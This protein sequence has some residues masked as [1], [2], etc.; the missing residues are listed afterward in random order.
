MFCISH[1]CLRRWM[2]TAYGI[3]ILAAACVSAQAQPDLTI[4]KSHVGNF[5][6]GTT[7][8]H[9]IVVTNIGVASTSGT[10]TVTDVTPAGTTFSSASGTG[11]TCTNGAGTTVC[12]STQFVAPGGS[13]PPISLVF[14]IPISALSGYTNTA[15]VSG[16]GESNTANN[17]AFDTTVVL[18]PADLTISK[19]HAGNFTAGNQGVY[20][21][22]VTNVGTASTSGTVTVTDLLP[23]GM[24]LA[25][26]TGSGWTCIGST[27]ISCTST[28]TVVGGSSFPVINLTVNVPADAPASLTNTATVAGGGEFNTANN[29]VNDPTTIIPVTDLT[30]SK[31]HKGNLIQGQIGAAYS[32]IVTN[33]G[34]SNTSGTTTVV[35]VLPAGLSATAISGSGWTCVLATLTCTSTAAIAPGSSFPVITVTVN[36]ATNSP[37]SVTN[38]AN[39]ASPNDPNNSNNAANDPTTFLPLDFLVRY[40]ANL[41]SGDAVINI[42]N[43]GANGAALA[44]PGFGGAAGNICMNVYAFSPDEQLVSCCSCLITPNGLVSLSVNQDL[45]NN[46]LTGVRP[47][48]VVVKLVNTLAGDGTGASCTNSAALAG[49]VAFPT[50]GGSMAFGTTVHVGAAGSF[51]V[52][53]TPFLKAT[54]S[55]AE[56]ASITNRCTNII[57]NGSTFGICRSCRGGGLAAGR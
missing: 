40:A 11:W 45:V 37:L 6:Q 4:S 39:V 47:N 43:T 15:N 28:Q 12:T 14:N 9:T 24:T 7:G 33:Q 1:S 5:V 23:G 52:A 44:G 55:P 16:G 31:S 10:V 22:T 48:S 8:T 26:F 53:E 50:A 42:T 25:S 20:G 56:L 46:T 13:L 30:I 41:T 54:L 19:S 38:S 3:M 2:S 17:S 21:I 27:T 34:P 32:I 35:D 18:A 57:G 51:P 29:T 36:V 49:S